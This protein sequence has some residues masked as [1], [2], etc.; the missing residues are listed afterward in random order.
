MD[1]HEQIVRD[2]FGILKPD[3]YWEFNTVYIEISRKTGRSNWPPAHCTC[4]ALTE[5]SGRKSTAAQQ[6]VIRHP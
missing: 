5:N 4:S 6:A 2:V 1:Y 3:E